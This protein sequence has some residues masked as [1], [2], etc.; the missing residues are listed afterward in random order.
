MIHKKPSLIFKL[1]SK[2]HSLKKIFQ[3]R[4]LSDTPLTLQEIGDQYN[5]SRERARQIEAR[6]LIKLKK[7]V[8]E[9]GL[10]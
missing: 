9:K 4:M 3:K 1:M 7:F 6:I 10:L 8:K 2:D 5:I